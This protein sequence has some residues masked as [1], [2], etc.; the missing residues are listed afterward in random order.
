MQK[1]KEAVVRSF[2]FVQPSLVCAVPLQ[3]CCYF[4]F[5][6]Q[7]GGSTERSEAIGA[8]VANVV[9]S[10]QTAF[11]VHSA[12]TTASRFPSPAVAGEAGVRYPL[13]GMLLF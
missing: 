12:P 10:R 13:A 1:N 4:G 6:R 2:S 3:G 7:C 11:I 5:P 9:F 8:L